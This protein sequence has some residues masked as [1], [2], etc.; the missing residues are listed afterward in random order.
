MLLG[1]LG[2]GLLRNTLAG[3]GIARAGYGNKKGKNKKVQQQRDKVEEFQEL[4]MDLKD[5]QLKTWIFNA[6]SSSPHNFEIQK[7]Y[8]NEARFNGV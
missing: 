1:I 4:V 6:A 5:L 2:A 3:K 8:Q 7:Y